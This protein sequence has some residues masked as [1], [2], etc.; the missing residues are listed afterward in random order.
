MDVPLNPGVT[1]AWTVLHF[2]LICGHLCTSPEEQTN[3]AQMMAPWMENEGLGKFSQE[4]SHPLMECNLPSFFLS[5][6]WI[7]IYGLM[8][9]FLLWRRISIMHWGH[10][11][12]LTKKSQVHTCVAD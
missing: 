8:L 5:K 4:G 10:R 2:I 12:L 11:L 3:S 9:F 7:L 1:W 6:N